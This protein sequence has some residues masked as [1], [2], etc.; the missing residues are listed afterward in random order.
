[1][2][3]TYRV[4]LTP[5]ETRMLPLSHEKHLTTLEEVCDHCMWIVQE[6]RADMLLDRD[7]LREGIKAQDEGGAAFVTL[8]FD[9]P[10]IKGSLAVIFERGARKANKRLKE[11]KA[12]AA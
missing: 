2:A 1:M 9:E 8:D 4:G 5:D 7:I 12:R 6:L 3:T 11:K 10:Q